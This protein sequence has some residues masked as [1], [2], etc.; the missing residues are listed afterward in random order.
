M[1][2]CGGTRV[3]A[4]KAGQIAVEH[5]MTKTALIT[6][7]TGQD[8]S[9]LAELLLEKG[10]QV[11][12]IKRRASLVQH[13][14]DRPHRCRTADTDQRLGQAALRRSDR[15]LEPD[16]HPGRDRSPTRS[17]T[18]A[19]RA[20]WR[21]A[22]RHRNTPPM[23]TASARCAC[24]KRSASSGSRRRPASTR[25]PPP[26]STAWCRRTRRRETTPFY[27]RSPYAVAK[28]YAYW[29]TVNYRESLRDVCLQRHPVQPR[30]PAPR[31]D[32]R[33]PQDHPRPGQ[34]R[35]GA[36]TLSLH[37]QH[38]LLCATGAT[39]RTTSGCSG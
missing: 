3:L 36:R 9:Y 28:L 39:P 33:D 15:H 4:T 34:H 32:L 6:G 12:G 7:I 10:Y 37:G 18:S 25:P 31:R 21:S 29:I 30:E 11:H 8:G 24:W 2:S 23:S 27:P 35:P 16:P 26:S 22:S 13:P 5:S 17:T 38:R 14:A 20:T 19:P 1:S